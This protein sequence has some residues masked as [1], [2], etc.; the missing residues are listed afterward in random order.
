MTRTKI[1]KRAQVYK[2]KVGDRVI[3]SR[4]KIYVVDGTYVHRTRDGICEPVS[5]GLFTKLMI[6]RLGGGGQCA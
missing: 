5:R 2:Y 6:A 3:E 1:T 4:R